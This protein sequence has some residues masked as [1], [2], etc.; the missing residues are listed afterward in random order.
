MLYAQCRPADAQPQL[1][2]AERWLRQHSDDADLL[3]TQLGTIR[4]GDRKSVV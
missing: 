4:L 3:L 1:E 2:Q